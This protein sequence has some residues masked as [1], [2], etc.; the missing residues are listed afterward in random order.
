MRIGKRRDGFHAHY[1][2]DIF[3]FHLAYV[4]LEKAI[5]SKLLVILTCL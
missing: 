4:D 1:S 2:T 5:I 3:D